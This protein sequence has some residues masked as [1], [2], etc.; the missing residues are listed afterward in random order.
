MTPGQ[1][2]EFFDSDQIVKLQI[3]VIKK[4]IDIRNKTIVELRKQGDELIK[5][6]ATQ[7]VLRFAAASENGLSRK[8]KE[9][10]ALLADL[11][12]EMEAVFT[13][14]GYLDKYYDPK[15]KDKRFVSTQKCS[16]R[17]PNVAIGEDLKR[18][19]DLLKLSLIHI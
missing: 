3:A 15:A 2:V 10:V 5:A 9:I 18:A 11:K 4:D 19:V 13:R 14:A 16:L 1:K 6:T 12:I 7:E 17:Y 8:G